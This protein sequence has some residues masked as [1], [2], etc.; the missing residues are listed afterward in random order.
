[1]FVFPSPRHALAGLGALVAAAGVCAPVHAVDTPIGGTTVGGKIFLDATHLNQH[2]SGRRTDLSGNGVDLKRSYL[3]IDHRFSRVWSA[4]VTT[5]INWTRDGSPTDLWF[6]HAYLQ[7]AFSKALVL[8]LGSAPM[9]WA[10]FVNH[11]SG[12]RYVDKELV[13]RLRYGA[14]AD[15]GVHLLGTLGAGGR[16]QY[17]TS[18]ISGSSFKRPR[19]GDR[20]D[21]EGRIAWQ[22]SANTVVA[23]GGYDGERAL[24]GGDHATYHTARRWDAM[25]AYADKRV[26]LGGQYFRATDWKQVRSPQGDRAS[27]WSLWASLKLN[28]Q[29][30]VFTR[31]DQADTS[32]W[33]DPAR[34]DRYTNLG[35]E[36]AVSRNLRVAAVYKHERVANASRTFRAFN[37][38][39]LWAQIDF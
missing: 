12:Y 19:T 11:W 24:G 7:G 29:W 28:P 31:H 33:L 10:G 30:A 34:H 6:K 23:V 26:R 22:P 36:W 3:D 16:V 14:S 2:R 38:V 17:A 5:D 18:M 1:M 13:T 4:H 8:R 9:P 35:L 21:F 39:G 20:P 25:A 15:W 37:E 32:E 27:G